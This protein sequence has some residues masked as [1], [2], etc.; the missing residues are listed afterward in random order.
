LFRKGRLIGFL[1]TALFLW[2]VARNVNPADLAAAFREADYRLVVPATLATLA[3]Y[4]VRTVR[5]Q[6]I[7]KPRAPLE[8]GP[9]FSVLMMGFAANNLLPA[10]L[11]EFVRAY[12]LGRRIGARKTF[13]MATI[14]LER[15]CDGLV[16]IAFLGVV[17]LLIPLPLWGQEVQVVSSA[18]FLAAAVGVLALLTQEDLAV[19]FIDILLHPL[20]SRLSG[21]L[22]RATG[23][24]ISG[25]HSLKSRRNLL[26]VLGLSVAVW[27]L[28]ALSYFLIT[29]A[30]SIWMPASRQALAALFLLV[31]VNLGIMLPSAPGYV[32]TFQFFAVMALG[33]F[34]VP[35]ETALAVAISSHLMQYLLVTGI[36]LL[37]FARENL[38]FWSFGKAAADESDQLGDTGREDDMALPAAFR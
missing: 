33:A 35:K 11:G 20:P 7:V 26:L 3:G 10:R 9:A 1:L 32:G 2:I 16:L 21:P 22:V 30:F 37:F 14:I 28:E 36:G 24:F 8:F 31:V 23:S 6:R 4:L 19:R 17:S 29:R 25:L 34:A 38:S 15:V 18:L 5:W 12:L 27:L 13:G